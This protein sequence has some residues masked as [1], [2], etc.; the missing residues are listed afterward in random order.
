MAKLDL[1]KEISFGSGKPRGKMPT[2]TSI[3]LVPKKENPLATRTGR[4]AFVLSILIAVA[5]I[6][7]L[8][9]RPLIILGQVNSKISSL[10]S[11]IDEANQTIRDLGYVE[12]EYAHYTTAGMTQ[13]E[14]VRA[15]RVKVMQLVEDAVV[16]S[17]V[18]KSWSLSENIMT[19]QVSGASLAELNQI[20][21]ALEKEPIVERC[22][23]NTANKGTGTAN[24][25]QGNVAV[26]F[27]VYLTDEE[28]AAA[29]VAEEEAAAAAENG[30]EGSGAGTDAAAAADNA[31]A[32][33]DSASD[34]TA[35][36]DAAGT[37][38]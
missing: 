31:A 6:G 29:L 21:A 28:T 26:S 11:Q 35:G 16:H 17:G 27:I 36:S 15:D 20:A 3:N 10:Q 23:I 4:L 7:Y 12:E 30:E 34:N 32:G 19:L 38:G 1:N 24:Q 14:L 13:E 33:T 25:N 22:V 2:K 18:V 8:V 5:L 9:V 37:E